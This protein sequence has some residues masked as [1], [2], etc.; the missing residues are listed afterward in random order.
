LGSGSRLRGA[1]AASAPAPG[2][3]FITLSSLVKLA[4]PPLFLSSIPKRA[5]GFSYPSGSEGRVLGLCLLGMT[6]LV[7]FLLARFV[8]PLGFIAMG[9]LTGGT[10]ALMLYNSTNHRVA[11]VKDYCSE[12]R[13]RPLIEEHELMHLNGE[14]SEEVVWGE[15]RKKYSYESLGLEG[16]PKICSF[17][18]IAKRLRNNPEGASGS[19]GS[20][21]SGS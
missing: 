7:G 14:R 12:C 15:A 2:V 18:P 21:S 16:D 20:Q 3:R 6:A 9:W 17:C 11:F 19:I 1:R 10:G 4:F 5:I 8:G 13:L